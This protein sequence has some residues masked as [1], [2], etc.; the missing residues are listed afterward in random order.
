M[1]AQQSA[2]VGAVAG[3]IVLPGEQVGRPGG[4]GGGGGV[5]EDCGVGVGGVVAAAYVFGG[6]R[7]ARTSDGFGSNAGLPARRALE[8][9]Q[10]ASAV[11][12][13]E[14]VGQ[15]AVAG[16]SGVPGQVGAS[17]WLERVTLDDGGGQMYGAA[18]A[19]VAAVCRLSAGGEEHGLSVL[20]IPPGASITTEDVLLRLRMSV[21]MYA[22]FI[23]EQQA[24]AES[25]QRVR[26]REALEL[27]DAAQHAENAGAMGS[28]F[29]HELARRFGC[30]RVSLGLVKR[31]RIRVSA[32]SSSDDVNAYSE[33]VELL[34]HAMDECA[35][36]E[37][38][39][40]YPEPAFAAEDPS[41]RR[42]TRAH[43]DLSHRAGPSSI[44]SLPLRIENDLVGVLTLERSANDPFPP[45]ALPL[46]RLIAE[47]IGPAVWTRRLADR[48]VLEVAKDSVL[49]F[50]SA[51]AGPRHTA[52][53]LIVGCLA[54][55]VLLAAV[56]P[57]PARVS[58]PAEVRS[59]TT[60]I[61]T[62]PFHGYLARIHVKPGDPVQVGQPMARMR[63]EELEL[64]LAE[65]LSTISRLRTERDEKI[66]RRE[67]GESRILDAQLV[68]A[69]ARAARIR[70]RLD[71][72]VVVSPIDGV[73]SRG[74]LEPLEGAYVEP[75]SPLF[76]VIDPSSLVLILRVDERDMGRVEIGQEGRA[77]LSG[78]PGKK[79]PIRVTEIRPV[80]QAEPG[81]NVYLVRVEL[82]ETPAG[83][84][85]G[86][87]GV[88]RLDSGW[89]TTLSWLMRP[90]VE[91]ARMRL[92]W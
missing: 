17:A 81:G 60:R 2:L 75:T 69:E 15:R 33:T 34:E 16:V 11:R 12:A 82:L 85:A 77:A 32:V 79:V 31:E 9:G 72:A 88:G 42:V 89:T 46:L 55:V 73:V 41:L 87:S 48:H 49:D 7:E 67:H 83:M 36:Q 84:R 66:R 3:V 43:A 27:L 20:L 71:R 18:P 44:V 19:F 35:D 40:V 26:L 22:S 62:P 53:K 24:L 25:H 70:D 13:L 65:A 54:I 39:V 8:S 21:A 38:E 30:T 28:V 50:A 90:V 91:E 86:L 1:L 58:A 68:E 51:L 57:I 80:S 59:A 76:E 64:E 47:Y 92:W 6:E 74:E 61:A 29:C 10:R 23:W 63:T 52:A 78:V 37:V 14:S 56:V 45:A 5:S 4:K